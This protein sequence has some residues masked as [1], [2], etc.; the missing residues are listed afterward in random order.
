MQAYLVIV[1]VIDMRWLEQGGLKQGELKQGVPNALQRIATT[2]TDFA[3]RG[4]QIAVSVTS[5]T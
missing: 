3:R 1:K 2:A 4:I 5:L